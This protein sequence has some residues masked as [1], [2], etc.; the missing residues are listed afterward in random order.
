MWLIS[1]AGYDHITKYIE[2]NPVLICKTEESLKE[3]IIK[4]ENWVDNF[5]SNYEDI[6]LIEDVKE[7]LDYN[8]DKNPPPFGKK[9]IYELDC[10]S[11]ISELCISCVEVPLFEE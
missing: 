4:F 10:C 9:I 3:N 6:A 2:T 7:Q 8:L 11:D 5:L 1:L